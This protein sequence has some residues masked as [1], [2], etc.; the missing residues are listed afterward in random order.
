MV[1][2]KLP[3]KIL[4][5]IGGLVKQYEKDRYRFEQF[6]KVIAT[7]L[8]EHPRLKP[9][10]HSIK[11]R[12]KDPEH[13]RL[14]LIRSAL[15][16][17]IPGK[18][19][20]ID[21]N[22]LYEKIQDLAGVRILHLYSDQIK[23]IDAALKFIFEEERYQLLEGPIANTWDDEYRALFKKLSMSVE[24]RDSLYTSIHYIIGSNNIYQTRCEIQVRTL[25][26]E[27]W[28]EVSHKV[29]YPDQI[30]SIACQEQIKVL[31]RVTSS[32]TRL[33]DSIFKSESEYKSSVFKSKG[34]P[35]KRVPKN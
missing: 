34:K 13:L 12:V 17:N 15:K 22:N 7:Q 29:N 25:S 9:Y 16:T 20:D 23:D 2:P 18:T 1:S 19:F 24:V 32:C 10:Y 28:G 30:D 33:V 5:T 11:F 26:E 3:Q 8:S 35:T 4:K 27:V 21:S 31:A 14:K 6:S